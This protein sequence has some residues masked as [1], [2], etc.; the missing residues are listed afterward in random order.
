MSGARLRVLA[1]VHRHLVPPDAL[2]E[3]TDLLTRPVMALVA[4]SLALRGESAMMITPGGLVPLSNWDLAT[5]DGF[6]TAYRGT[7]S[8]VSGGRQ[9]TVLAPTGTIA[10]WATI[11]SRV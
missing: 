2:P 8:D 6:P 10:A 5:R 11:R 9:V 1:L 7:V 3:G 4:R